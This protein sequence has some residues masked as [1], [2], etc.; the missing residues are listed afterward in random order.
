VVW[1]GTLGSNLTIAGAP[2][3]FVALNICEKEDACKIGL[4][5]FLSYTV[6]FVA[7][8]LIVCFILALIIWVI[9]FTL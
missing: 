9:P 2:A 8:T 3:L 5:Q 1:A 6:P 4:K 7:I